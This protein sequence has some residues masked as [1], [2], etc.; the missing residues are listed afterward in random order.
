MANT[1]NQALKEAF[2]NIENSS[3]KNHYENGRQC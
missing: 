3:E 1:N 2:M